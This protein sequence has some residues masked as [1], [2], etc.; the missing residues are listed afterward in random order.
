[1][2]G[3]GRARVP[4]G[5]E[6]SRAERCLLQIHRQALAHLLRQLFAYELMRDPR[7]AAITYSAPWI[8]SAPELETRIRQELELSPCAP[9]PEGPAGLLTAFVTQGRAGAPLPRV[10][11]AALCLED[12]PSAHLYL[13]RALYLQGQVRSAHQLAAGLVGE[14]RGAVI[15]QAAWELV[16]LA[17]HRLRDPGGCLD[18]YERAARVAPA[19]ELPEGWRTGALLALLVRAIQAGDRARSTWAAQRLDHAAGS[20][21]PRVRFTLGRLRA[22]PGFTAAGGPRG[23]A[24][25]AVAR[26]SRGVAGLVAGTMLP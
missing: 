17:R 19:S 11:A 16:G 18:A 9:H 21:D 6:L 4:A 12:T 14:D 2:R 26:S 7:G 20:G 15:Q 24:A 25:R 10:A 8:P 5:I 23:A 22:E 13:G 3:S 1:M